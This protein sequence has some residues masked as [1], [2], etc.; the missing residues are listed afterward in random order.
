MTNNLLGWQ[1]WLLYGR[2]GY[3]EMTRFLIILS[4]Y[5]GYIQEYSYAPFVVSVA[6]CGGHRDLFMEVCTRLEDTARDF[7]SQ[8]GWQH[9]LRIGSPC[10]SSIGGMLD[11]QVTSW[12]GFGFTLEIDLDD[13]SLTKD[14]SRQVDA[15]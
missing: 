1:R 8:H 5:A 4:S 6:T 7:L 15:A 3:V 9:N 12:A 2:S 11:L 14:I 10:H 13:A